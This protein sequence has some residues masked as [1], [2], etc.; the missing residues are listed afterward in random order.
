MDWLDRPTLRSIG[1]VVGL[2]LLGIVFGVVGVNVTLYLAVFVGA[3]ET[4][5]GHWITRYGLQ[6]GFLM[7]AVAYIF[8]RGS[9]D[10]FIRVKRLDFEGI[11]WIVFAPVA[12]IGL[13]LVFN[14]V[15]AAM[16]IEMNTTEPT[17]D[18][19]A[20]L[21]Q[22]AVFFVAAWLVAAPS[23]ELLFRGVIQGRLR[24]TMGP[25]GAVIIAAIIFALMHILVGV[26]EGQPVAGIVGWGVET[27]AGGLV[28]GTAYERTENLVV[29]SVIHATMWTLPY[30]IV[31]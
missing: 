9:T 19:T 15:L 13:S 6:Y 22:F 4:E 29:P 5:Y 27:F 3:A 28:F 8:Y 30:F 23:E 11:V 1:V 17:A 31:V 24:E 2:M 25:I 20:T 7:L 14:P 21:A 12:L 26:L 10:Q 18:P 16:G